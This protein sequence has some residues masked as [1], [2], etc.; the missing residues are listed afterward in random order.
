MILVYAMTMRHSMEQCVTYE[1]VQAPHS[2]SVL[3]LR[4]SAP[5]IFVT[6]LKTSINESGI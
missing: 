2:T 4:Y 1:R 6:R 3:G 5:M